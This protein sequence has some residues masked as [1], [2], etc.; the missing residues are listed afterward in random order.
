MTL[1]NY[2]WLLIWLFVAGFILIVAFPQR[3]EHILGA[4]AQRWHYLPAILMVAPYII[5]AGFRPDS[6]GDTGLYRYLFQNASS[7]ITHVFNAF[8][9]DAKDPGYSALVV[10]FKS[11][12][13][14][15]DV[16]FFTMVAIFQMLCLALV[17]RKYSTDYWTSIFL[18]VASTDYISWMFNGMRQFIAVTIIF[19]GFGLLLKKKYIPLVCIILLASTFHASALLMLP[20]IFVVQ[21]KAW[22]KKMILFLAIALVVIFFVD[23]FTPIL[24]DL[25]TDTQYEGITT[26]ELWT[27]DDGTNI[28]RMLVYSVPAIFS[29]IGLKYVRAA[30]D[31]VINISVNCSI[32]AMALYALSV[33]TSGIYIGRLPIF[34][35]LMGYIALPWLIDH[36]FT[37]RSAQLVKVLMIVLYIGFFYYQMFITW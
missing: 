9:S 6:I 33:A 25:L 23:R 20:V 8:G 19:A 17:F 26:N 1:T 32:V 36:M 24:A 28:I 27:N 29:L 4:P 15:D 31:P 16:L 21:G 18:F 22:S 3:E 5:W 10:L 11:I 35:S 14:N 34:T 7:D 30:D 12:F 37:K 2:W 13:G